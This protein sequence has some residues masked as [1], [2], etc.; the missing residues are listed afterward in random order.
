MITIVINTLY[1]TKGYGMRKLLQ[2]FP[3][4]NWTIGGLDS[5]VTC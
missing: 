2:Q 5:L 1:E 4:K 3:Q